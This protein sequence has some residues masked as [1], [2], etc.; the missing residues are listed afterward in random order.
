MVKYLN[1]AIKSGDMPKKDNTFLLLS[2]EEEKAKRLANVIG[3]D[4]CRR[5]LDYL[6]KK[7]A[8]ETE[9]SRELNMPISTVH[10]NLKQLLSAGLVKADEFHYSEKGREVDH[11]SIAN[12]YIIIAP[13]PTESLA[14]KLKRILPVFALVAATGAAMQLITNLQTSNERVLYSTAKTLG[15]EAVQALPALPQ[16]AITPLTP[17][18]GIALWFTIGALF[19]LIVYLVY[20]IARERFK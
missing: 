18:I 6:A 12:K 1:I 13:K 2:L 20:D 17:Q 8:T 11:Y 19:A 9:L 10:Y 7:E 14:N 4:T 16:Q 3:S 15:E 5:I